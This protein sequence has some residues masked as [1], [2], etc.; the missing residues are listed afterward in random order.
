MKFNQCKLQ[1]HAHACKVRSETTVSLS[2]QRNS[3]QR[4]R[5]QYYVMLSLQ[6]NVITRRTVV[7]NVKQSNTTSG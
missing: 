4:V 6:Y 7:H 3:E 2:M 5:Q 1:A